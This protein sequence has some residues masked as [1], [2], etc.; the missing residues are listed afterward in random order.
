V[1]AVSTKVFTSDN[2]CNS[3]STSCTVIKSTPV[4][5]RIHCY[6]ARQLSSILHQPP[7]TKV[8]QH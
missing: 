3:A 8:W 7:L 5:K 2:N 4:H 1:P 6:L